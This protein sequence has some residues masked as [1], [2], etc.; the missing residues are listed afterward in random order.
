MYLVNLSNQLA[1]GPKNIALNYINQTLADDKG[2]KYVFIIP[3]EES[4]LNYKD[5]ENVSFVF[6]EVGNGILEKI[7]KTTRVNWL[8]IPKICKE[9][10][11][12][13]ILAFGNFLTYASGSM[14]K[15][16]LLHHP[17]IIDD[18]LVY[19]LG[20]VS[21]LGELIKRIVFSKTIKNVNI[22]VVQSQYML[23]ECVKKFPK[24]ENKFKVIHNPLSENFTHQRSKKCANQRLD[25][26]LNKKK[27]KLL[28]V[29][30]FY[31]HKNHEFLLKLAQLFE[32]SD[33]QIEVF[34][35]IDPLL[36]GALE[37]LKT[38]D[39]LRLPIFNLGEVAHQNL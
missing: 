13:G 16:V 17:H 8:L 1:S 28:Y 23:D 24:Y 37:F 19:S 38:V 27:Y 5:S 12:K 26:F 31:P 34:V 11:I 21:M 2:H 36:P 25:S 33:L 20:F 22:V 29:S 9:N 14:K 30:R 15:I 39:E 3:S 6:V 10:K 7:I 4:Y 32:Q 18:K 35:T